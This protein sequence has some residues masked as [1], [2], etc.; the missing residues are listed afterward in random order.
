MKK[1][2]LILLLSCYANGQFGNSGIINNTTFPTGGPNPWVDVTSGTCNA[3]GNSNG[4]TGNGADDSTA[5][6]T[7]LNKGP[8]TYF[9]PAGPSGTRY[10]RWASPQVVTSSGWKLMCGGSHNSGDNAGTGAVEI[11][12]DMAGGTAPA[13]L[14]GGVGVNIQDGPTIDKSCYVRDI[15]NPVAGGH[16]PGGWMTLLNIANAN[17]SGGGGRFLSDPL[18]APVN[19]SP[20]MACT[21]TGGS[22]A[23]GQT[24]WEQLQWVYPT[25]GESAPSTA[26]S[27]AVNTVGCSSGSTCSC[28]PNAPASIP[29]NAIG[30][31]VCWGTSATNCR[32]VG[33]PYLNNVAGGAPFTTNLVEGG[34]NNAATAISNLP[35]AGPLVANTYNQTG[36]AWL[37]IISTTQIPNC[38]LHGDTCV[39]ANAN[40]NSIKNINTGAGQGNTI[41]INIGTSIPWVTILDW[42]ENA[43]NCPNTAGA[44]F[45]LVANSA[46]SASMGHMDGPST[47]GASVHMQVVGSSFID[48]IDFEGENAAST[49]VQCTGC[50]GANITTKHAGVG[51]TGAPGYCFM[52]DATS[53]QNSLNLDNS[54]NGSCAFSILG[55]D[56]PCFTNG[57]GF[58][59]G[60]VGTYTGGAAS[61]TPTGTQ[62][63][64]VQGQAALTATAANVSMAVPR[65][66]TVTGILVNLSAAE[67]AAATLSVTLDTCNTIAC[68]ATTDTAVTCTVGNNAATCN[69]TGQKVAVAAGKSIV[70][71][72]VQ[73]GTGSA[74]VIGVSY[75]YQ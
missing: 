7:C 57:G 69:L 74:Q 33:L 25:Y 34:V 30:T 5:I 48:G 37:T 38:G 54:S 68:S 40:R 4:A 15:G 71:K 14:V 63:L 70:T 21:T 64:P 42:E 72:T 60:Q 31:H 22:I 13:L 50:S 65:A 59:N 3:L 56:F 26:T 36:G 16:S 27:V 61:A 44:C 24:I 46:I 20:L 53:G 12:V 18:S 41:D 51:G 47:A 6:A 35:S 45:G 1:L 43:G 23:T 73:T 19:P 32:M 8:G 28:T 52:E 39:T 2:L 11:L 29:T 62:F 17:I 10:Y 75:L 67:G 49:D 66:L 55:T 58:C 9:L